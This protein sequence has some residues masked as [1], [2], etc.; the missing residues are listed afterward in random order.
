MPASLTGDWTVPAS[1]DGAG[2]AVTGE[3]DELPEPDE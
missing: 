3:D 2:K 1:A